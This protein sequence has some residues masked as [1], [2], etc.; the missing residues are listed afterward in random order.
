M[1]EV[2]VKKEPGKIIFLKW[3]QCATLS[4]NAPGIGS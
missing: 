4:I 3:E 1:C 2:S